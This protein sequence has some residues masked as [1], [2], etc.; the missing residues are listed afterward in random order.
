M[1]GD[2]WG[3]AAKGMALFL[4]SSL[5]ILACSDSTS[6]GDQFGGWTQLAAGRA[7][8][9]ALTGDGQAYC[10]GN[11]DDGQA[12]AAAGDLDLPTAIDTGLRFIQIEAGGNNTC[13]VT[14]DGGL[15][16]WG[17]NGLGGLGDGGIADSPRPVAVEP[18]LTWRSVS[19]GTYHVC[20]LNEAG[21]LYCWGGDRWDASLGYR[22][23]G[24]CVAPPQSEPRWPCSGIPESIDAGG[25]YDWV[26]AGLSQTCAGTSAGAV[27]WGEN[28][29]RQ[30]GR[31]ATATCENNDP[32]HLTE[33]ACARE[34]GP[35]LGPSFTSI[36][37][38]TTHACGLAAGG[39]PYCWGATE[40]DVGQLG[41][42][43]T[44]GSAEPSAVSNVASLASIVTSHESHIR[45]V[46]CGIDD[47]GTGFCWGANRWGQLGGTSS[48]TCQ[49]GGD[50]PCAVTPV[51]IETEATLESIAL[52]AEFG[53]A[54]T[55]DGEILCWGVN[56]AGQLGDGSTL[57]RQTPE[58]VISP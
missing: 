40:L 25:S 35:P 29:L 3:A 44:D 53:C 12:G 42:G 31:E 11:S 36:S 26:T 33:R 52:G 37:P 4:G 56:D 24:T 18:A 10:W 46:S 19:V 49:S 2:G 57:N 22:A 32:I 39:A 9:C 55:L 21:T 50:T 41:N 15:H 17:D 1:K 45:T 16:C 34:P 23:F 38:G 47:S 7:H 51:P 54:L 28:E 13:G 6:P 58:M 8:A 5:S 14:A 30:L 27:C 48:D 20:A 43:Q